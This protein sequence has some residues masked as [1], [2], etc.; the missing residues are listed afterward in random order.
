MLTIAVAIGF[1]AIIPHNQKQCLIEIYT[2]GFQIIKIFYSI[3]V[4]AF[5]SFIFNFVQ[6]NVSSNYGNNLIICDVCVGQRKMHKHFYFRVG[7]W[8]KW[9]K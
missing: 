1:I 2:L 6:G 4:N 3:L 9:H 8:Y 7:L 5:L